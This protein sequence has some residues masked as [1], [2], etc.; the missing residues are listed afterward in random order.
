MENIE[1]W[2]KSGDWKEELNHEAHESIDGNQFY[3]QYMLNPDWWK[4]AF[5]FL[6]QDLTKV[7][8]GK[9]GILGDDVFAMISDYQTKMKETTKW[10]AHRKYIDLQVVISGEEFM[11][12]S[13]LSKVTEPEEYDE[14]R[15]LIFF[16]NSEGKFHIAKPGIFFPSD[17][18]MPGIQLNNSSPV[19]KLVIKIAFSE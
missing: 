5:D 6:K 15:D 18:H 3:N 10:E 8:E 13:A 17:A 7:E 14:Q 2:F 12:I 16:G 19:R 9:Y 11:G 1:K 4:A